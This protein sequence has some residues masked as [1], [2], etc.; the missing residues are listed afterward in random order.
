[1]IRWEEQ[2]SGEWFGYSGQVVVASA[3][4][5]NGADSERWDW[6]VTGAG[7][8]KGARNA[9]HRTNELDARR[10]ADSY[11]QRWLEATALRPDLQR[12]AQ[13]SLPK[14]SGRN[15][16][17]PPSPAPA[18][19]KAEVLTKAADEKVGAMQA[20]L[21]AAERRA[22]EAEERARVAEQRAA[23]AEKAAAERIAK[24]KKALAD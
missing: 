11:W 22:R 19:Q 10:A 9:G 16:R 20:R 7:R 4:P 13:E 1:M 3:K 24:L 12:L 5:H 2:A 14:R 23:S 8:L 17:P 18:V 6:E 21:D 15:Q